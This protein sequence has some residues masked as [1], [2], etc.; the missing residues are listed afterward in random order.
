ML[1]GRWGIF[2]DFFFTTQSKKEIIILEICR[3]RR[4]VVLAL[5]YKSISG[6]VTTIPS[7]G[8]RFRLTLTD[9][10]VELCHS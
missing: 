8:L 9:A 10:D 4:N 6:M 2:F 1:G 3:E 5:F 7:I